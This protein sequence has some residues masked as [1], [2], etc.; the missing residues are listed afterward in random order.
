MGVP[1][2]KIND[3]ASLIEDYDFDESQFICLALYMGIFFKVNVRSSEYDEIATVGGAINLVKR[4]L[5][6][7]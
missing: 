5:E 7:Y 4:K 3:E 1:Q 6:I 2:E